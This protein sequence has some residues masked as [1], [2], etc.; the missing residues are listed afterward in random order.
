MYLWKV[1]IEIAQ[2]F[3]LLTF[4]LFFTFGYC[5]VKTT[6]CLQYYLTVIISY[7]LSNTTWEHFWHS[8]TTLGT[9]LA[10]CDYTV[11]IFDSV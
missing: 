1:E 4:M 9:F 5:I 8:V 3:S 7:F 11:N 10:Q 6:Y 2:S